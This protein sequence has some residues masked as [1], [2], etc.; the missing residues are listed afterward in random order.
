MKRQTA[1]CPQPGVAV[2]QE[3]LCRV[4]QSR[5]WCWRAPEGQVGWGKSRYVWR[6]CLGHVPAQEAGSAA[7]AH[8]EAEKEHLVCLKFIIR[9]LNDVT[10]VVSLR[11]LLKALEG[12]QEPQYVCFTI[13][14]LL[15]DCDTQRYVWHG[16]HIQHKTRLDL[17]YI[18]IKCQETDCEM[19]AL[20]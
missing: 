6:E 8:A 2:C 15:K 1:V 12:S 17:I 20:N 18:H 5:Q 7:A 16:W 9:E 10:S 13:L 4:L 14:L 11:R 3:L 19:F